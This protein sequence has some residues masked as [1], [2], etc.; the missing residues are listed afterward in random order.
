MPSR[1]RVRKVPPG[2]QTIRVPGQRGRRGEQVV[3]VVPERH[4]LTRQL[5][6]GIALMAWDHRRALAP[7][8]LALAAF[9]VTT[10]LHLV[11]WWSGVIL[12]PAAL[13]PLVWLAIVQRQRP[14]KGSSLAW[15]IALSV[16]ATLAAAWMAAGAIFGPLTGP[17]ELLW[18][19][20][21]IGTQTTWL[22]VRRTNLTE[23]IA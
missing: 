12:A 17:L 2:V 6:S 14:A 13:A 22:V 5:L 21:L 16:A 10:L 1:T 11:A 7:T 20:A 19:L 8:S 23:E 3:I 4:S 9:G 18:L 15:R